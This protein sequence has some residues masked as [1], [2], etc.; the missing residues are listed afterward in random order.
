MTYVYYFDEKKGHLLK[1]IDSDEII[2]MSE[3]SGERPSLVVTL[4][5]RYPNGSYFDLGVCDKIDYFK[6]SKTLANL[7]NRH[8]SKKFP[9]KVPIKRRMQIMGE[10]FRKIPKNLAMT[11]ELKF[12]SVMNQLAAGK[13]PLNVNRVEQHYVY[14]KNKIAELS[15]GI[16]SVKD[17]IGYC[18]RNQYDIFDL[19]K[20]DYDLSQEKL[21]SFNDKVLKDYVMYRS[22]MGKMVILEQLYGKSEVELNPR[23]YGTMTGRLD[24]ANPC[25]SNIPK[26]YFSNYISADYVSSQLNIYLHYY[27]PSIYAQFPGGDFYTFLWKHMLGVEPND[28][29]RKKMKGLL[30]QMMNGA[31]VVGAALN[32]GIK[33]SALEKMYK[34]VESVMEF[35]R[36]RAELRD[37]AIRN[38]A[39]SVCPKLRKTSKAQETVCYQMAKTISEGS[40]IEKGAYSVALEEYEKLLNRRVLGMLIQGT[41]A[42]ILKQAVLD[43]FD[44]GLNVL[45]PR[46]DEIMYS[47]GDNHERIKAIMKGAYRKVMDNDIEVKIEL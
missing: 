23:Q 26:K 31:T 37:F 35:D 33:P 19:W 6:G 8:L 25:I 45:L 18:K 36:A 22:C 14:G 17:L 5:Q 28:S 3:F 21:L 13:V 39:Y 27:K 1:P 43:S 46:Y 9:Q 7:Y 29:Q 10:V 42:V 12:S 11:F 30:I 2:L 32:L 40:T 20:G 34:W 15:E 44:A 4:N 41:E 24:T 38:G 16:T 47:E